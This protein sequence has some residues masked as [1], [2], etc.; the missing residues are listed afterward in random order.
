MLGLAGGFVDQPLDARPA[1]AINRTTA[2]IMAGEL[3][4]RIALSG[5]RDEFDQ[6]AANLNAMLD[7]I[8]R[9]LHGMRQVTDNIAHDL[10]TP[11]NRHALADRGGADGRAGQGG[12]A[13]G[14]SSRRCVDADGLIDTFNALLA[15]ARAEAGSA[16]T[17][18]GSGSIWPSSPTTWPSSTSRWPRS[19]A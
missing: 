13:R 18:T 2:Q 1:R 3:G 14:C 19:R 16:G 7:R 6:L 15:I 5:T 8:E 11:L 10:R 12:I 9:L 17:A 4:Q